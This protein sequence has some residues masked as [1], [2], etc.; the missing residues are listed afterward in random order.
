MNLP[1]ISFFFFWFPLEKTGL[2]FLF[3]GLVGERMSYSPVAFFCFGKCIAKSVE[4]VVHLI[5]KGKMCCD[6]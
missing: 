2:V 3:S 6:G 4:I 1:C 5:S